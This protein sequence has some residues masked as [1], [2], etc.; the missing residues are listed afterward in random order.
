MQSGHT[1]G[2]ELVAIGPEPGAEGGPEGQSGGAECPLPQTTADGRTGAH[3]EEEDEKD[4][5]MFSGPPLE[6]AMPSE[7]GGRG[8]LP[9]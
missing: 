9:A 6:T 2:V 5:D 7:N 4:V 3:A 8:T 1:K